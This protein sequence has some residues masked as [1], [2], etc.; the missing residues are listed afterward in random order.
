[1]RLLFTPHRFL[2]LC[3]KF[4]HVPWWKELFFFTAPLARAWRANPGFHVSRSATSWNKKVKKCKREQISPRAS[5][6]LGGKKGI[7]KKGSSRLHRK[8]TAGRKSSWCTTNE[9]SLQTPRLRMHERQRQEQ[10]TYTKTTFIQPV[11]HL[12]SLS[13]RLKSKERTQHS[14]LFQPISIFSALSKRIEDMLQHSCLLLIQRAP[15]TTLVVS[16]LCF[17]NA[18]VCS[19]SGWHLVH[20]ATCVANSEI[21]HHVNHIY[22]FC[23]RLYGWWQTWPTLLL[24]LHPTTIARGTSDKRP[25]KRECMCNEI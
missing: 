9:A 2:L 24:G 4:Q 11:W 21:L 23:V 17:S 13:G 20:P 7:I 19:Q 25:R 8:T 6:E 15:F 12:H 18:T 10:V 14:F 16:S 1:M 22:L 5:C 3:V